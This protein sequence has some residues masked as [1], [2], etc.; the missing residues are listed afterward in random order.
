MLLMTYYGCSHLTGC[1]WGPHTGTPWA[2]ASVG[3]RP[4]WGRPALRGRAAGPPGGEPQTVLSA[5]RRRCPQSHE[6]AALEACVVRQTSVPRASV[7][8]GCRMPLNTPREISIASD[9]P[10]CDPRNPVPRPCQGAVG[11]Y[12][13]RKVACPAPSVAPRDEGSFRTTGRTLAL[14]TF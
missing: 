4:R 6:C 12:Q 2:G 1:S 13:N 3:A 8:G 10:R 11:G 9:N 7:C 5:A 14:R